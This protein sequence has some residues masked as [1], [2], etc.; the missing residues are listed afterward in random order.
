VGDVWGGYYVKKT[1]GA[2]VQE[3]IIS[4]NITDYVLSEDSNPRTITTSEVYKIIAKD[5]SSSNKAFTFVYEFQ[6]NDSTSSFE[7]PMTK[8]TGFLFHRTQP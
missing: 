3:Y 7:L 4:S 5:G 1:Y 6:F 2:G 8:V